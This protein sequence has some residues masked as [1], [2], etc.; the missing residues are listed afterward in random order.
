MLLLAV[1]L[2][3]T[4]AEWIPSLD[5]LALKLLAENCVCCQRV[6]SDDHGIEYSSTDFVDA[7]YV[8]LCSSGVRV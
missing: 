3:I 7:V 6:V 8:S 2:T 4:R 1:R 5:C